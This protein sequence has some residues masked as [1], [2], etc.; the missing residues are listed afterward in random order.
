MHLAAAA[1]LQAP[2]VAAGRQQQRRCPCHVGSKTHSAAVPELRQRRA[3]RG[4][5]PAA[6]VHGATVLHHLPGRRRRTAAAASVAYAQP[7]KPPREA[8]A[9]AA[10]T[11]PHGGANGEH[12]G[13]NPG[14]AAAAAAAAAVS[15]SVVLTVGAEPEARPRK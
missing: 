9:A 1:P 2:E 10:P 11:S 8:S 6:F 4:P 12:E 14:T 5:A 13:R 7:A 3:T 15:G